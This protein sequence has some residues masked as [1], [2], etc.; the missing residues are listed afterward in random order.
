MAVIKKCDICKSEVD[1]FEEKF[2]V[3]FSKNGAISLSFEVDIC[4]ACKDKVS[5][6]ISNDLDGLTNRLINGI[7]NSFSHTGKTMVQQ[8]AP[9]NKQL[10]MEDT[11]EEAEIPKDKIEEQRKLGRVVMSSKKP[12]FIDCNCG[13]N[14]RCKDCA[15]TGKKLAPPGYKTPTGGE[16]NI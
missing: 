1:D 2:L 15:G 9:T 8:L 13:K 7:A 5:Y 12:K 11:P 6:I 16:A 14:M 3:Q 10:L 4:N